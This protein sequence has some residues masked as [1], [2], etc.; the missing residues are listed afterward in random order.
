MT[1][2]LKPVTVTVFFPS[3][4]DVSEDRARW[5]LDHAIKCYWRSFASESDPIRDMRRCSV[6]V[7]PLKAVTPAPQP[8]LGASDED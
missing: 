8:N 2:K 3:D 1:D 6:F 4:M 5:Y 7:E